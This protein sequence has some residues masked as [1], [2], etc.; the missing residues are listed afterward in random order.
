MMTLQ[1]A[2]DRYFIES[3]SAKQCKASTGPQCKK[4][5]DP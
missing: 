5:A 2:N 4:T 3:Q 1:A